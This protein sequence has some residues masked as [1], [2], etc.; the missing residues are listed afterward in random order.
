MW[1]NPSVAYITDFAIMEI[2]DRGA[3]Y[4]AIIICFRVVLIFGEI[5]A[6]ADS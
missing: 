5:F 3:K 1:V 6:A 2:T 4:E